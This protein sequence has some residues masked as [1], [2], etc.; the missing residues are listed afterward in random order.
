MSETPTPE[1][2]DLDAWL[3]DAHL[4]EDSCDIFKRGDVISELAEVKT[5]IEEE[6]AAD[7]GAGKS[8][9]GN[10]AVQKL[11]RRYDELLQTFGDS[12]VTVYV[13]AL[14]QTEL[15]QA[16]KAHEAE[17]EEQGWDVPTA[18][19]EFGL[20]LLSAAIVGLKPAG[21]ERVEVSFTVDQTR[22]MRDRFGASQLLQVMEAR[23]RAQNQ[24]PE[25]T[26]DFLSNASGTSK[27]DTDA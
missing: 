12:R 23:R 4:P 27:D 8:M 26:V 14:S 20:F 19:Q 2:F 6:E 1:T 21:Q 18:N 3:E 22:R 17:V 5:R 24:A 10:K 13:R 11:Q 15:D 16:K 25:V 7:Q 9:A